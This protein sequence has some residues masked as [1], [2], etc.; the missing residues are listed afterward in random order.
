MR[1]T[2]TVKNR[3]QSGGI[4]FSTHFFCLALLWLVLSSLLSA[5]LQA[6]N[7]GDNIP[8]SVINA[9]TTLLPDDQQNPYVIAVPD[10]NKWFV[11]W[12]DWR[13]WSVSGADIYGRFINDDGTYCGDEI[14]ICTAPGNQ[15]V[16]VAAYRD[17]PDASPQTA[18]TDKLMVAWQ[19]V[20]GTTAGGYLYY[21]MLDVSL[22]VPADCSGVTLGTEAAVGYNSIDG[23]E[24]RS[25]KLPDLA[26]DG[27]RDRFWLV[28]V[29][30]RNR[31][32]RIEEQP[33]GV[34]AYETTPRVAI[35][36]TWNFGDSN[37]VAYVAIDAAV[38]TAVSGP[39]LL[40]N[41]SLIPV[42]SDSDGDF[43]DDDN[44]RDGVRT[45]RLISHSRS[46]KEDAY[47]YE[48]F[49]NINNV[50]VACDQSSPET[51]IVW[52]GVRGRATLTITYEDYPNPD[53]G[54]GYADANDLFS[55]KMELDLWD[56]DDGLTHI[57]ALFDKYIDQTVVNAQLVDSSTKGCFYPAIGFDGIHRK[58]LVVWEDR[59]V[60]GGVGD[61]LHSKIFGQ[62]LYSGGGLYGAN[63]AIGFQDSNG[64]GNQDA[65]LLAANQTRPQVAVDSSNQRFFVTWQDGRNSQVSLENLDIYG[66]FVDSEGSLRGNNYAVCVEPANQYNPV[67]AYNPGNH[68]FLTVWKDARNLN[69]TNSDIYGQRFTLGQPQ[70]ILLNEDDTPLVPPLLDFGAV[71]AGEAPTL[72]IKMKNIGDSTMQIG[73]VTPLA[74]PF[75]YVSLPPE[76]VAMDGSSINLVPGASY[77]LYVRFAP[78]TDGTFIDDFTITSDSTS[79]RVNLQ[80]V[81]VATVPP[82][83]G[84]RVTPGSGAFG[85]VLVDE[86]KSMVFTFSNTGNV[87]VDIKGYDLSPGFSVEGLS[88]TILAGKD[89]VALVKFE[90]E[91][92]RS[93]SGSL[94]V[95]YNYGLAT[96]E[97]GLSGVGV[98]NVIAGVTAPG[99]TG[100]GNCAVGATRTVALNFVNTGNVDISVLGI[101]LPG[102]VFSVSGLPG[103]IAAYD[104][105][106]VV[107]S[108][109]PA[110]PQNYSS[111]LRVIY[112]HG[113]PPAEIVFSGTG[114]FDVNNVITVADELDFGA[115]NLDESRSANL[116]FFN[117]GSVDI[118]IAAVDLPT[119]AF[120]VSGIPGTIP[121]Q[122]ALDAMVIFS[123]QLVRSYTQTMRVLYDHGVVT[124]EIVFSGS[125]VKLSLPAVT[126]APQALDFGRTALGA[127]RSQTLV[128]T[129]TG[130]VDVNIVAVDLPD[131]RF[132]VDGLTPGVL[133][134][135]QTRVAV[136]TFTPDAAYTFTSGLRIFFDRDLAAQEIPLQG[137][138]VEVEF[139]P[140]QL[141]FH[142][143]EVGS[144]TILSV[145]VTNASDHDLQV[146]GLLTGTADFS[147]SGIR[148]GDVLH[149]GGH[150]LTCQVTFTPDASGYFEDG[151]YISIGPVQDLATIPY[152]EIDW[153]TPYMVLLRATVNADFTVTEYDSFT[154]DRDYKMAVSAST[155]QGGQLFILLSHDPLS[156]GG[157]YALTA[158]GTLKPFPYNA[159]FGWQSLAYM[160][161]ASS[162]L[163]LDLSRVDLRPLGC[164]AC[165]GGVGDEGQNDISFGGIVL[166][167]PNRETF[168]NGSDFKYLAGTLYLATYIKDAG[169]SGPFDFNKGLLEMQSLN[170]HSLAGTWRVTSRY[171]EE[172]KTHP[173][174][175]IVSEDG[176]GG[177]GLNW[178]E[179]TGYAPEILYN[180]D[181]SGYIIRFTI[182]AGGLRYQ[183]T[184]K[185]GQLTADSFS[186]AYSCHVNGEL[187]FE[188]QLVSGVRVK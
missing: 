48:Y 35:T 91:Q 160:N 140:E 105:L 179:F 135:G 109:T 18:G 87:D 69:T 178:P 125:G 75:S 45:V 134:A 8:I 68:Q 117:N 60:W 162:G 148:A 146:K 30:G 130:D 17:L 82:V 54:E 145:T 121:A 64:D 67:T 94:R 185:I 161:S 1:A 74:A 124:D 107:A 59:D 78:T 49:S 100:F 23:D 27:A 92:P 36:T 182:P 144:R 166:T 102:T 118:E 152:E 113:L 84:I 12:E 13:N 186:G 34:A 73:Y 104:S 139:S 123:P 114:V 164:S 42:D 88:G 170:L 20:R 2:A 55:A 52:E 57:Y 116:R 79:L 47:V 80:G 16:P 174:L 5:P 119:G 181:A 175:L 15:T 115:C 127:S 62:L 108:F 70:L 165:V 43:D 51:L 167:P 89:L 56:G 150:S 99:N 133:A 168:S 66:Q 10:K 138:G 81:S 19:D 122:G 129:N 142:D 110:E 77:K 72:S 50:K 41:T 111:T 147:V 153:G 95:F 158:N 137:Q 38:E 187:Q 171:Y 159:S 85:S 151:L 40:R 149:A 28:W 3:P 31:L 97:I 6:A 9:T 65:N 24:L 106:T 126:L 128:L 98:G 141:G 136:V 44:F 156:A 14:A 131:S 39:E 183:Y 11:V 71:Q 83:A 169:M 61:G 101:D 163:K 103:S 177:L 26:Y 4:S 46:D 25:R 157:I 112:D 37:A 132:I 32:Q 184:Y 143:C 58:F 63:L 155:R 53:P 21:R 154:G 188:D 173:T 180:P 76:L 93:Y 29:E 22:L 176:Q 90:P 96:S 120:A 33:F 86:S 7:E 172:D